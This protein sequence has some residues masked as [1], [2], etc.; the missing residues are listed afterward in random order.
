MIDAEK[1]AAFALVT[2]TTSLVPG[3]SML[4]VMGQAI[5]RGARSG[6]AALLGMQIG[7]IAWW[8]LAAFGL[9]T[10]AKAYPFAFHLLALAGIAYLAW[11]GVAAIRHSFHPL[12][13]PARPPR[14]PSHHAFRD[15][16]FVAI[17][18]PKS[19][20]YMVAII[21]PFV[22][23]SAPVGWQILVLAAVALVIDLV[24]G[25]L[26][27]GAGQS[28]AR[29]MQR[30]AARRWIDRVIGTLFLLIAV[31]VLAELLERGV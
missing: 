2:A 4:F 1:L 25:A 18:N 26:Y 23:A 6:W 20:I 8:L 3:Q 7:Y 10:L 17:G 27:I 22:D 15:G 13:D 30:A 28:L 11:L 19:L 14:E 29:V 5:W 12:D 21:P 24:V 9:G 16:I 31:L